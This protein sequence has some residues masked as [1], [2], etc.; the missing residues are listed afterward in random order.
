[1]PTE[2]VLPES[3][4]R[5]RVLRLIEEG[6]LPLVASTHIDAAYGAGGRCDLCAQPIVADKIEYDV[7][8]A[9]DACT[10]LRLPLGMA[11]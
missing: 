1:M 2:P 6:Q 5:A 9:A 7:P 3:E 11:A 10:S 4:L 8:A